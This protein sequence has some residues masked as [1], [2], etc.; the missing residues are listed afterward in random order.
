MRT[1]S[2]LSSVGRH[3]PWWAALA[4]LAAG[5]APMASVSAVPTARAIPVYESRLA[6][7]TA[8]LQLL[9][10]L[11]AAYRDAGR[12]PE[13]RVLLERAVAEQPSEPGAVLLLGLT[14]E[15]LELY[16]EAAALYD[17]YLRVSRSPSL[18]AHV[19]G[20]ARIVRRQ[21]W[22]AM[23]QTALQREAELGAS[24][25]T[26]GTVAVFPF[27]YTGDDPNLRSLGRALAEMLVTDL[28]QT[29][30]LRV[31]ERSQVQALLDEARLSDEG[32]TDPASGLR[33]GRLLGAERVVQGW[34]GS[35]DLTLQLNAAVISVGGD[36]AGRVSP[37]SE[38]DAI[39]RLFEMEKRLAFQIYQSLGIVLTDAERERVNRRPTSNLQALL[40]YGFGLEAEDN[41]A[42]A[43]AA[44]HFARAAALDPGFAIARTRAEAAAQAARAEGTSTAQLTRLALNEFGALEEDLAAV[45]QLVPI[46]GGRNPASEGLLQE[47]I[48]SRGAA[49][50]II[51]RPRT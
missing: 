9:V 44:Q 7:D 49:V 39:Q 37:V 46:A 36:R 26:P 35:T 15:D 22:R 1:M 32:L 17:R 3:G 50:R 13:A 25:P 31:L 34:I 27:H 45:E 43:D 6:M 11:A 4:A 18:R 29:D 19:L 20:R 8:N 2:I 30:R 40:W 48:G 41:G 10:P 38:Q 14:Y 47:T 23:A 16:P 24:A 12:M 51:V 5:C 21:Q 42:Y 33:S 28:A